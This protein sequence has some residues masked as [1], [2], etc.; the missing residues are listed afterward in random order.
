MRL[1]HCLAIATVLVALAVTGQS[2]RAG[3]PAVNPTG[4]W[5]VTIPST[6][7]TARPGERTLK[8]KLDGTALTGTL[9]TTSI[10]NGQSRVYEWPIKDARLQGSEISFT[11]T[12]PFQVGRGVETS[13]YQG[14]IEGEV[15][16]GTVKIEF[17][18][19]TFVRDWQAERA[20]E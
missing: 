13:S 15:M 1:Q 6:N 19:H 9:S 14:R 10:V 16:K 18:G 4:T 3:A 7:T 20:N 11:V 17:S 12:H 2:V 8:L 5:K